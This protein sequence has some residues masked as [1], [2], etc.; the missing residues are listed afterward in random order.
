M[1]SNNGICMI[2]L[3]IIII[4]T[5]FMSYGCQ[6]S[7]EEPISFEPLPQMLAPGSEYVGEP[8]SNWSQIRTQIGSVAWTER[9]YHGENAMIAILDNGFS[10][11]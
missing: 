8:A 5:L 1:F 6:D 3:Y 7:E 11:S 9:G 2:N 4:T 10:R